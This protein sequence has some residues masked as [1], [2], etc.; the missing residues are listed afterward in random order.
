MIWCARSVKYTKIDL[1]V[2]GFGHFFII[3]VIVYYFKIQHFSF[4]F[5]VF[6]KRE[7]IFLLIGEEGETSRFFHSLC[8]NK[9]CFFLRDSKF[10][11]AGIW[12]FCSLLYVFN[13]SP[14]VSRSQI[15]L[16]KQMCNRTLARC[17]KYGKL[18]TVSAHAQAVLHGSVVY[19][20]NRG[21]V[22][23]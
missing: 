6:I 7:M 22:A 9:I 3:I 2:T 8:M 20:T 1:N 13:D 5:I 4:Y 11:L 23:Q 18:L 15:G 10:S 21:T 14:Q 12:Q 17:K 16:L 19:T